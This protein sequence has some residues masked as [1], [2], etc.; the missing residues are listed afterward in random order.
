MQIAERT[1]RRDV[2]LEHL[3]SARA[4]AELA[5]LMS[6][7][8]DKI[9]AGQEALDLELSK[10]PQTEVVQAKHSLLL[11]ETIRSAWTTL[12]FDAVDDEAFVQLVCARLIEPTLISDS[13]RVLVEVGMEPAHRNT[14]HAA[15]RRCAEREYRDQFATKCFKHAWTCGDISLVLYDVTT[16]MSRTFGRNQN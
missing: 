15:L 11:L 4:E 16:L 10:G 9:H 5:T 7:G 14:F 13:R 3:G 1:N 8:R 2:V 12:G 6:A